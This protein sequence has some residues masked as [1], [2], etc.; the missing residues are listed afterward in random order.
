MT[1]WFILTWWILDT[2]PRGQA[3]DY[4]YYNIHIEHMPLSSMMC[5]SI[6]GQPPSQNLVAK[7]HP[8][9]DAT[10]SASLEWLCNRNI[11]TWLGFH[12]RFFLGNDQLITPP[13]KPR[14]SVANAVWDEHLGLFLGKK[15]AELGVQDAVRWAVRVV[16]AHTCSAMV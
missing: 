14:N 3:I 13:Q 2:L 11:I 6:Y 1:I 4:I 9:R 15:A 12:L 8:A 7:V 10:F 16:S 5:I